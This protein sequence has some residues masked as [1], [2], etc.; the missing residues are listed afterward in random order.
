M[1]FG[2]QNPLIYPSKGLRTTLDNLGC[3]VEVQRLFTKAHR[4]SILQRLWSKIRRRPNH[5]LDLAQIH[6]NFKLTNAHYK[7]IEIVPIDRIIGSEGRS[8]DFDA[9]FYPVSEHNRERWTR[10][11]AAR[12]MH[13]VLPAPELIKIEE[14][15]F[16]RDGHHRIS[17]AKF[18]GEKH[19]DGEVTEWQIEGSLYPQT[20]GNEGNLM[21]MEAQISL[22]R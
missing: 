17:V 10:I 22:V 2:P 4:L 18:L 3:M 13:V 8:K 9:N 1:M 7:G 5:L 20:C 6:K 21:A 15:Y 11:A 14:H 12:L 19:V 16:V